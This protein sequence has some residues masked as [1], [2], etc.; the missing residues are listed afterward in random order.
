MWPASVPKWLFDLWW[1][2]LVSLPD[3]CPADLFKEAEE[4]VFHRSMEPTFDRK[5][6]YTQTEIR[7]KTQSRLQE[8]LAFERQYGSYREPKHGPKLWCP[9]CGQELYEGHAC[10]C[11]FDKEASK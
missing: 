3:G 8:D 7:P 4:R 1:A 9:K 5:K 2:E 11:G 6:G 10:P